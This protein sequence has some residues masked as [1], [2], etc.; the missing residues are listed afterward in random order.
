MRHLSLELSCWEVMPAHKPLL[1]VCMFVQIPR[2]LAS[3]FHVRFNL[4]L[5][6]LRVARTTE[7]WGRRPIYPT[8]CVVPKVLDLS[9]RALSQIVLPCEPVGT[10]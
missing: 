5:H 7:L 4:D 3:K 9:S 1:T 10:S 6:N 2:P 8:C